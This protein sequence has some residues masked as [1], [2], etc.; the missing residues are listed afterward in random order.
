MCP[1]ITP[2][3]V[4]LKGRDLNTIN[5][6][7]RNLGRLNY[8]QSYYETEH[9]LIWLTDYSLQHNIWHAYIAFMSCS[10]L[11]RFDVQ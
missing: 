2:E 7:T 5:L 1:E 6:S 8:V 9:L 3:Y 10:Y 11:F 4:F